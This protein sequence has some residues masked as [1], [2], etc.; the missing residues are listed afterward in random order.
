M[1]TLEKKALAF[2]QLAALKTEA[3]LDEILVHLNK[4]NHPADNKFDVEAFY[5]EAKEK[6]SDVLKKLAQ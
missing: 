4:L 5:K 1:S 2:E 3:A 6:Y